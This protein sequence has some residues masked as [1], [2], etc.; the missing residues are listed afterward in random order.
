[1]TGKSTDV[2]SV[3]LHESNYDIS[4]AIQN[5]IDGQYEFLDVSKHSSSKSMVICAHC[6]LS[7][8]F[9][10]V[11]FPKLAEIYIVKGHTAIAFLLFNYGLP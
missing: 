1:M 10:S 6:E 2:I 9:Q 5:I 11:E 4:Q 8:D 7:F 3:A